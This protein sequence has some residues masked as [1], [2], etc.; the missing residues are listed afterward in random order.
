MRK[1]SV[2]GIGQVPVKKSYTDGLVELGAR[3]SLAALHDAGLESADALYVGNMLASELQNQKHLG[4]FIA[5]EAG[6]VGIEAMSASA[7]SAAGAAALRMAYLAVASGELDV[8]IAVGVE[9]MSGGAAAVPGLSKALDANREGAVGANMISRNADLMRQYMEEYEVPDDGFINFAVN[10][11]RNSVH[12]PNA[13]FRK[14]ITARRIR[15]SRIVIPPIRLYDSAPISDG[16]AALVL[17][18][19]ERAKSLQTDSVDLLA[20]TVAT[21]RFRMEDRTNPLWLQAAEWSA[22]GAYERAGVTRK[23]LSFF[24]VHDAFSI[25]ATLQLEAAGF[26]KPGQGWRLAE[27]KEIWRKGSIPISTMGGLKA[28]GHPI[29][30]SA[31]YQ[32]CEIVLQL[33]ERAGKNQIKKPKVAMMQS[34]GGAASTMLTHIFAN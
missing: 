9:K 12:N 29:G 27:E 22:D 19:S 17:T 4:A 25:M 7:A 21:D 26:A 15:N 3:V 31:L 34:V 2:V 20:S 8:A 6:L 18:S 10:A 11:H 23:D 14:K 16:A 28:R 1:V 30:A 5:D 32:A 33:T 24:E 13:M